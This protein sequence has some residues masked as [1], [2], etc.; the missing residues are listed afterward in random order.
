MLIE[1]RGLESVNY[2]VKLMYC[3][4]FSDYRRYWIDN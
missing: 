1:K 4:V 2:I 3:H